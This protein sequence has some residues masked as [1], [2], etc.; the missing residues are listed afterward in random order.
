MQ[1]TTGRKRPATSPCRLSAL[2]DSKP[3]GLRKRKRG[4]EL[5]FEKHDERLRDN[6]QMMECT[7]CGK[8]R[9]AKTL[10]PVDRPARDKFTCD[11]VL[12]PDGCLQSH[13]E[14]DKVG[15]KVWQKVRAFSAQFDTVELPAF[16]S[17]PYCENALTQLQ[18]LLQ[19]WGCWRSIKKKGK[20]DV[21]A[22]LSYLQVRNR[23]TINS[24][25]A[26]ENVY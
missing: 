13:A 21:T 24:M 10:T 1:E 14:E 5:T 7:A 18:W 9:D 16:A 4:G 6:H 15:D 17:Q 19:E 22:G 26:R 12:G 20:D 2:K 11:D 25:Q 23:V 3:Y 8:W